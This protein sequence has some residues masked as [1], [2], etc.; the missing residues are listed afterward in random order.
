MTQETGRQDL[1]QANLFWETT[2]CQ[3]KQE[4]LAFLPYKI[5]VDGGKMQPLVSEV[6][7]VENWAA[8]TTQAQ[9]RTFLGLTG[10]HSSKVEPDSNIAAPLTVLTTSRGP[11]EF[12]WT[13]KCKKAFNGLEES[14]VQTL[15]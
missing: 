9:V 7:I 2:K 3:A 11:K 13:L 4:S 15:G 5:G 1:H 12:L 10:K 8:P 6:H 14:S